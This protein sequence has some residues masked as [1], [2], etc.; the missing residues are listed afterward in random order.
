MIRIAAKRLR[1]ASVLTRRVAFPTLFGILCLVATSRRA[2][3]E[4][5][6]R[7]TSGKFDRAAT[8]TTA[9]LPDDFPRDVT[10]E[11]MVSVATGQRVDVQTDVDADTNRRSIC[12]IASL[13]AQTEHVYRL[14]TRRAPSHETDRSPGSDS[15]FPVPSRAT[16]RVRASDNGQ[17]IALSLGTR[18]I[19][20]YHHTTMPSPIASLPFHARSGFLSDIRTP[21]GKLLTDPMPADHLHQ[22][23]V[24]F[25]WR[26]T[27]FEGR[28]VNFWEDAAEE[29]KVRHQQIVAAR[30]GPVFGEI[31]VQLHHVDTT[32]PDGDKLVLSEVWRLRAY[33][34]PSDF[35]WDLTSVQRNVS[36]H[37]L[38]MQQFH[39][40]G[41]MIRGAAEWINAPHQILTQHGDGRIA[42]NHTRPFWVDIHGRIGGDH[43]GLTTMGHP[44]NYRFP[45]SVRLHPK[46]PY[47]CF[48]PMVDGSF[49]IDP[50]QTFRSKF[51]FVAH[52]GPLDRMRAVRYWR[53]WSD[54]AKAVVFKAPL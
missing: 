53:D 22:H 46:M 38:E 48:A 16:D 36:N 31:V 54:P 24:M 12:W 30:S 7:V 50:S 44:T 39:Y 10:C 3:S 26:Q 43:A 28:S 8:P 20:K 29:G 34:V 51:R 5:Q 41:L 15:P 47:Y 32:A 52:D 33:A 25:A 18:P 4:W 14:I 37:P 17:A 19:L 6:V 1:R 13:P 23:G 9:D 40:G 2:D 35:V 45:Q 21:G 49:S 42:G 11:S 27:K